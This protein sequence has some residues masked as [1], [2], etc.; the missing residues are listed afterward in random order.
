MSVSFHQDTIGLRS[1]TAGGKLLQVIFV[2]LVLALLVAMFL[3]FIQ[4][5]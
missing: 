4:T 3:L 1:F 5:F 2:L